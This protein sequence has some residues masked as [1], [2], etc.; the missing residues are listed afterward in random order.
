MSRRP[1]CGPYVVSW[2]NQFGG[3]VSSKEFQLW[4]DACAFMRALMVDGFT[5][6]VRFA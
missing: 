5:P 4:A 6:S 2:A 1:N 3:A